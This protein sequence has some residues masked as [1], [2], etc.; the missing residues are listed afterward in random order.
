M[1]SEW[2][3]TACDSFNSSRS[4]VVLQL[5]HSQPALSNGRE[6]SP[7]SKVALPWYLVQNKMIF[8]SPS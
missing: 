8:V 2:N 7:K 4:V 3:T 5:D 6:P 1:L